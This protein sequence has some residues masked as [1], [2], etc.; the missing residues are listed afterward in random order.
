MAV[1]AKQIADQ[2]GISAAAV[3]LA[4]NNRRGVSEKTR[5]LVLSTAEALGY[6]FSK[7]KFE[8]QR[9]GT[10]ALVAFNRRRIFASPFFADMLAGVEGALRHAGFSFSLVNYSPFENIH[11]QIADIAEAR[12]DGVIILATEMYESDF[13]PFASLDCPLLLLDSCMSVGVDTVKIDNA[14]SMTLAVQYLY[15]KY[16]SVPGLLTTPITLGNFT[17]RRFAYE[18]A[19]S[20]LAGSE[21]CVIIHELAVDL[22]EA[23]SGMLDIIDSGESL[24]QSYVAVFDDVAIGAMKAFIERGYRVPDDVRIV[25]FDNNIGGT[26]VQPQLTTLNV[27]SQYM[28][29]IAARRLVEIIDEAEHHPLKIE[30]GASLIKRRSA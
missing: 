15:S 25:G 7:I 27:P 23:Y 22:D 2:L 26:Y 13:L 16:G 14:A 29:A 28:G 9:S 11:Q 18:H 30:L 19:N 21:K 12:Y 24:A 8:R 3:S 5:Q 1:T 6:D 10:V 20:Q 4:L 17:E